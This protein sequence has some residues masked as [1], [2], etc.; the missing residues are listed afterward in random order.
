MPSSVVMGIASF[1]SATTLLIVII[2][3]QHPMTPRQ[4]N[5]LLVV[6]L[7]M[8]EA[9]KE[10]DSTT[11]SPESRINYDIFSALFLN[12]TTERLQINETNGTLMQ[13]NKIKEVMILPFRVKEIIEFIETMMRAF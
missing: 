5:S 1:A 7:S 2:V 6:N 11:F 13:R 10:P 4:P 12:T 3:W 9:A 8:A